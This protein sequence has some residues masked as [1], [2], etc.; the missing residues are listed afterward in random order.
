METRGNKENKK[1]QLRQEKK[2]TV[3]E[4]KKVFWDLQEKNIKKTE[5]IEWK[6]EEEEIGQKCRNMDNK[7][8][9]EETEIISKKKL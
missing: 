4:N 2:R 3:E 7:Q 1:R 6:N 9:M 8:N 5:E